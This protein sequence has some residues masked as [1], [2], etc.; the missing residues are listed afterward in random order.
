MKFLTKEEY[1]AIQPKDKRVNDC[2]F[3]WDKNKSKT[4][5]FL[6]RENDFRYI[7]YPSKPC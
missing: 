1:D 5:E 7:I 6:L 2:P 4:N 3:C